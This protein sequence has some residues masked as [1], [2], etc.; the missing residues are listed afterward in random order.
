MRW[1]ALLC[2]G[3]PYVTDAEL[4]VALDR[5]GDGAVGE[6]LGGDDCDDDDRTVHP[7]APEVDGDGV[8]QDCD[9]ADGVLPEGATPDDRDAD[10]YVA[11][12]LGGDDCD[13][14]DPSV[15][16]G[17]EDAWYDGVDSDCDGA[18][19]CDQ[20]G[21]GYP[22]L[23]CAGDD[24]DDEDPAVNP[25]RTEVVGNLVDDDCDDVAL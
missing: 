9:G 24:C 14:E 19:D 15:H 5:D 21:D 23:P 8:D 22:G 17:A 7:G 2:A 4:A 11:E 16:P 1:L 10:G 13:D 20:D 18:D 3:C 12:A 25:G 6:A